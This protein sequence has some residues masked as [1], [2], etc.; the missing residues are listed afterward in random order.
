MGNP[1]KAS[2]APAN[3]N[4]KSVGDWLNDNL[5]LNEAEIL[6]R[7]ATRKLGE[8]GEDLVDG[9]PTPPDSVEDAVDD[10]GKKSG[11]GPGAA[12]DAARKHQQNIDQ[13]GK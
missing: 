1:E 13:A 10:M 9:A 2:S 4:D 5:P 7:D 8:I 3:D 12:I 11:L 6:F